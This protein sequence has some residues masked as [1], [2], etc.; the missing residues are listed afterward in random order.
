MEHFLIVLRTEL[1]VLSNEQQSRLTHVESMVSRLLV[2]KV[3]FSRAGDFKA[4]IAHS[5]CLVHANY[6]SL[7]H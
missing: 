5:S 6:R 7:R 1:L 2:D 4:S 3:D